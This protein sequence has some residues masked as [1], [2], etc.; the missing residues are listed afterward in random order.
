MLARY[1]RKHTTHAT[2]ASTNNT[3]SLKLVRQLCKVGKGDLYIDF[4]EFLNHGH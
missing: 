3:T 4:Q 2:G 1:P